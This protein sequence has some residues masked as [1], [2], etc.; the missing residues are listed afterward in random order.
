MCYSKN[1]CLTSPDFFSRTSTH[2][3]GKS[4]YNIICLQ[5]SF[6]PQQITSEGRM[7]IIRTYLNI[8]AWLPGQPFSPPDAKLCNIMW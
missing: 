2:S 6:Y 8:F 1:Q 5:V 3:Q 4:T 7:D